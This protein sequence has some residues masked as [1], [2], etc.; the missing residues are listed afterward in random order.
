MGSKIYNSPR[1]YPNPNIYRFLVIQGIRVLCG[2]RTLPICILLYHNIK[3]YLTSLPQHTFGYITIPTPST[4]HWPSLPYPTIAFTNALPTRLRPN[5]DFPILPYVFVNYHIS[6][7]IIYFSLKPLHHYFNHIS[8]TL[9]FPILR[10]VYLSL[11]HLTLPCS[12]PSNLS[13]NPSCYHTH[14]F[15]TIPF[16]TLLYIQHQ[17]LFTTQYHNI[18]FTILPPWERSGSGVECLT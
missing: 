6:Y 11:T 3:T 1:I 5:I 17:T 10:H 12:P 4:N 7:T 8:P 15:P 9:L 14:F 2:K 13:L 18:P 16:T